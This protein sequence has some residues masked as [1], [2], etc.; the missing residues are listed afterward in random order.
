MLESLFCPTVSF[1]YEM[2]GIQLQSSYDTY[3]GG[4]Q[5]TR[6]TYSH[7][8]A[9]N[10]DCDGGLLSNIGDLIDN[11][12]DIVDDNVRIVIAKQIGRFEQI[13]NAQTLLSLDEMVAKLGSFG[14]ILGNVLSPLIPVGLEIAATVHERDTTSQVALDI[15]A[16]GPVISK[17]GLNAWYVTESSVPK[18][19]RTWSEIPLDELVDFALTVESASGTTVRAYHSP[20]YLAD[21]I[22]ISAVDSGNSGLWSRHRYFYHRQTGCPPWEDC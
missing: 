19:S 7:G 20:A 4:I 17:M 5:N 8:N 21:W 18:H 2:L 10:V 22:I 12:V 1:D 11:L 13:A 15:H 9:Y 14:T 6:V 16:Q 3:D